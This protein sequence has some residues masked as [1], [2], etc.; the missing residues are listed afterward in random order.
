MLLDQ[1]LE[2]MAELPNT[3]TR[4]E[5]QEAMG[6]IVPDELVDAIVSLAKPARTANHPVHVTEWQFAAGLMSM[7]GVIAFATI[8]HLTT[9]K[10]SELIKPKANGT[11][12]RIRKL[13]VSQVIINANYAA[14]VNNRMGKECE[15]G[16]TID[17]RFGNAFIAA[18]RSWGERLFMGQKPI[19]L[20][21]HENKLYLETAWLRRLGPV[22]WYW[23]GKPVEW[24]EIAPF[25][26][27]KR[28]GRRQPQEKKVIWRTWGLDS[29]RTVSIT[30]QQGADRVTH[31]FVVQH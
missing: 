11:S 9:A 25:F 6:P 13:G 15:P 26:H 17:D 27:P 14:M 10:D 22:Y 8:G 1:I 2:N 5:L 23:D 7:P 31:R 30:P 20:V 24:N 3:A 12:G 4:D 18:P 19:G 29:I 21:F 16:E 28:E